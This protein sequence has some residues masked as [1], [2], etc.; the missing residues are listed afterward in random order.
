MTAET[1]KIIPINPEAELDNK[2]L[3]LYE[4]ATALVIVDQASYAIAGEVGK[5]LKALVTEITNFHE[6]MRISAKAAYDAVLKSKNDAL[7]PVNEAMGIV[8]DTMNVYVR[9]QERIR[10]EAERKAR[11]AAE[12][13]AKKERERL[14]AQALAAMEKGKGEKADSLLE[15]AEMVYAA[16]VTIAPVIDK[17]VKTASGNIT[18]AKELKVSVTNLALF[19]KTL[20]EQNPGAVA[21]IVK[22]GDGPLKAFAKS[23]GLTNYPGLTI[24]HT[25][26]VRL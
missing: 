11:I 7:A 2:S 21:A 5:D 6:P 4:K 24:S 16:P 20:C 23:N 22:I 1:A 18:Q 19:L 13:A 9:E 14:E 3:T 10:Q 25:V 8:R 26:G 15:K 12:E 17:T